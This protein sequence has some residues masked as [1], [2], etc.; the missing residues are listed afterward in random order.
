[1]SSKRIAFQKFINAMRKI[2]LEVNDLEICKRLD[3]LMATSKEDLSLSLIND[4]VSDPI[5]FDP[6]IIPEPFTQYARHYVYMAKRNAK[7]GPQLDSPSQEG[8]EDSDLPTEPSKSQTKK[9]KPRAGSTKHREE[10]EPVR[11]AL[12]TRV[13]KEIPVKKPKKPK[14]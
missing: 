3:I 12:V 1:M 4:L 8:G 13:I 6:K 10:Q 11:Q 14:K 2:S 7:L 9:P 5:H